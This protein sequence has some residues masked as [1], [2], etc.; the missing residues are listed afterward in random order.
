MPI[1]MLADA[2]D[3]DD[4]VR[5]LNAGATDCTV[6][7]F[8]TAELLA[9]LRA[10]F[11]SHDDRAYAVFTI[12]PWTFSPEEKR[13]TKQDGSRPVRLGGKEAS[14]LKY[15]C[16]AG[17]RIVSHR[18]LLGE[19]W[20]YHA[21]VRTHTL[22]TYIYRLRQSLEFDP[23][24]PLFLVTDP[25]GYRLKRASAPM[26]V[27]RG[28]EVDLPEQALAA[29]GLPGGQLNTSLENIERIEAPDAIVRRQNHGMATPF[30]HR[31]GDHQV[32]E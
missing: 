1:V 14:L 8:R 7:P 6:M 12:G 25:G 9:R 18:A 28:I 16:R 23:R 24:T 26:A 3:D 15:F 13:L 32:V 2:A 20:G 30:E 27:S 19:V 17:D 31:S 10:A 21:N 22:Q 29:P 11:R 5:A 4:V